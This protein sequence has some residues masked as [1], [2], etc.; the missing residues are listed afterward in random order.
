M[1]KLKLFCIILVCIL[2]GCSHIQYI[3]YSCEGEAIL[4][5]KGSEITRK[6][7][8]PNK[9]IVNY[10]GVCIPEGEHQRLMRIEEDYVLDQLTK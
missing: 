10:D 8:N 9:V 1:M 5:P 7:V 4:V 2:A 6:N 3:P